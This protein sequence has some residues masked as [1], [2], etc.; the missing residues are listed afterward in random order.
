MDAMLR[1]GL[2]L[3]VFSSLGAS[4]RSPNFIVTAPTDEL[5]RHVGEAAEEY[6]KDLAVEWVGQEL[7]RWSA[8]CPINVRVGNMGAGGA[9]TF[10]FDRGEVFGW[11]MNIQGTEERILD[12][13]LPHEISHT[14]FA[15]FFRRPLPRWADEGAA[16]LIEHD[17]ERY[18]LKKLTQQVMGTTQMIP[19]RRLLAMTEYPQNMQQVLTLYAQGYSLA[20]YLIQKGDKARY[21][22]FL[23]SAEQQ[24][25]DT[26]LHRHFGYRKVEEL[27]K[28]WKDWVLAGSPA[29]SLPEG[30]QFVQ[31]DNANRRNIT[32]R[33]QSPESSSIVAQGV[34]DP[35]SRRMLELPIAT[36]GAAARISTRQVQER[37]A[38]AETGRD[39]A[40]RDGWVPTG[41]LTPGQA[42]LGE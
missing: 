28:D 29:I 31:T 13:V 3:A 21:L 20:D 34:T 41:Q 2:L 23:E 7:P 32:V 16:S 9:T 39:R 35:R 12:S 38:D 26:A 4:Y 15:C 11:N 17:S 8:P 30:Q 33:G 1:V 25:W 42:W 14:I 40:Y 37:D 27:E 5:A 18:R 24:G 6:R 36:Q 19:L 10:N 22:K